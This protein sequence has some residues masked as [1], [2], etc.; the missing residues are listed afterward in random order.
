MGL[1]AQPVPVV[2]YGCTSPGVC[3]FISFFF[4]WFSY[5]QPV[6]G[7]SFLRNVRWTGPSTPAL[8]HLKSDPE[9]HP[10]CTFTSILHSLFLPCSVS[11]YPSPLRPP[12]LPG[13]NILSTR[14]SAC[15]SQGFCHTPPRSL[16]LCGRLSL[17]AAALSFFFPPPSESPLARHPSVH[18]SVCLA[19]QLAARVICFLWQLS[20]LS[21][22]ACCSAEVEHLHQK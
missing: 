15:V 5:L 2:S 6:R 12:S 17:F 7:W 1:C 19:K 20:E 10:C 18:L 4:W 8:G 16:P 21:L 3:S 14:Q 22:R 9:G 11:L 13:L